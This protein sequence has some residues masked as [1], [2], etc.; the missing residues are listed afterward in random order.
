MATAVIKKTRVETP[1]QLQA[2]SLL[3]TR[4]PSSILQEIFGWLSI[5][6]CER[7]LCVCKIWERA[8]T[9]E[10]WALKRSELGLADRLKPERIQWLL[11]SSGN[12]STITALDISCYEKGIASSAL[13]SLAGKLPNLRKVTC[14][15]EANIEP[16]LEVCPKLTVVSQLADLIVCMQLLKKYP[17]IENVTLFPWKTVQTAKE[18]LGWVSFPQLR[19]ISFQTFPLKKDTPFLSKMEN[20]PRLNT[21]NLFGMKVAFAACA[22]LFHAPALTS[23]KLRGVDI[24]REPD[25]QGSWAQSLSTHSSLQALSIQKMEMALEDLVQICKIPNLKTLEL[26]SNTPAELDEDQRSLWIAELN[27]TTRLESLEIFCSCEETEFAL[28]PEEIQQLRLPHL[29]RLSITFDL[30]VGAGSYW[31]S[32]DSVRALIQ[33]SPQLN[34]FFWT[35][36]DDTENHPIPDEL[37]ALKEELENSHP[38][39]NIFLKEND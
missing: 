3:M 9:P 5:E 13:K 28:D 15:V 36:N 14:A 25:D 7:A 27:K 2:Q 35:V 16:F 39:L 12:F 24:I 30:S 18:S 34:A 10:K 31:P 20:H 33:N 4:M 23:L 6:E 21:V 22:R 17:R 1:P 11:K 26:A 38:H 8:I 32:S 29:E 19:N 37:V